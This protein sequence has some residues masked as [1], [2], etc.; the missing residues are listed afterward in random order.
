MKYIFV[1]GPAKPKSVTVITPTIGSP[2]LKDAMKSVEEQTY[3]NVQHLVVVDG[4]EYWGNTLKNMSVSIEK[5]KAKIICTPENTGANG[6][7]GQRIYAAFPHLVNSDYIFFLDQD[8]WYEPDHITSL[9]D[10]MEK[11]NL[12]WAYSLR[13]IFDSDKKFVANDDCESLGKW[14]IFF[15]YDKPDYMI[16]T[17]AF[18]FKKSFIQKSCHLWHSGPWGEDR[19]YFN[20][21]KDHS[22]WNTTGNYSL[23][24]R[25]DGNPNSV[26]GDFFITGNEMMRQ[27]YNGNFPWVKR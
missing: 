3:P 20:A 15:T 4:Q 22:R 1:D 7:N 10:L 18:A 24:Y 23:C 25:L 21:I 6:L 9:V 27:M 8:N 13:K 19:R 2:K 5:A 17:S 14:P 11:E 12:D 16:D 26:T